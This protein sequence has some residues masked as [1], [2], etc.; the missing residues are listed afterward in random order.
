MGTVA[1]K[2]RITFNNT[3][4]NSRATIYEITC[5]TGS[6]SAIDR[7]ALLEAYESF[8][9]MDLGEQFAGNE[10]KQ[11]KLDELKALLMNTTAT[12]NDIDAYTE[13]VNTAKSEAVIGMPTTQE[14][15]DLTTHNLKLSD[16]IAFN[17]YGAF[18]DSVETLFPDAYVYVEYADGE[19]E[20][21]PLSVL[22][23]ADDGKLK[24]SLNLAAA[25]MS[26]TVKLRVIFDGNNCGEYIE[27]SVRR[28]S[29]IILSD[30]SQSDT[31]KALIIAMLDYGA[32]AQQYFGYNTENLANAGIHAEG[33]DPVADVTYDSSVKI[34]K[35][36]AAT[37]LASNGWSLALEEKV[38]VRF[39][40]R[41]DNVNNYSISY[42]TSDG[43]IS[44]GILT[45]ELME[46][47]SYRIEVEIEDASLLDNWYTISIVNHRDSTQLDLTFSVMCYVEKILSGSLGNNEKL[48]NLAKAIKLYSAKANEYVN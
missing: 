33:V 17:F 19:I 46:D 45:P 32:Y 44:Y 10:I 41:A 27:S 12:Q 22:E 34:V 15:G 37:G 25:E 5:T 23:V 9:D 11:L 20:R 48:I 42:K 16:D 28:Y 7:S 6:E 18:G 2:I 13:T 4:S 1:S 29:D 26:D 43:S 47:G 39:Y 24:V 14:Y 21:Y 31:T 36:G 8:A 35:H 38:R 40:F 30:E 3:T